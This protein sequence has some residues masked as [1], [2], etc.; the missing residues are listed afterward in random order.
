VAEEQE[1]SSCQQSIDQDLGSFQIRAKRLHLT[2]RRSV[3]SGLV[4]PK[5]NP[6][7]D[8]NRADQSVAEEGG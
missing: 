1:V 8:Q 4:H 6:N 3:A 2:L 7:D 5:R